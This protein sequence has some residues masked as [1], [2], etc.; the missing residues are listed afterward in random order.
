MRQ[1]ENKSN[2][3]DGLN[4]DAYIGDVLYFFVFRVFVLKVLYI[5]IFL[6]TMH[7]ALF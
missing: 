5:Y 6:W 4:E 1:N 3:G 2:G 7:D